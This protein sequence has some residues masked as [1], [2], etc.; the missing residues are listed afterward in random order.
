MMRRLSRRV[1]MFC[2]LAFGLNVMAADMAVAWYEPERGSAERADILN[3]IRPAIEAQLGG[4]VEFVIED[5]RVSDGWAFVIADPQRPGGQKID[6][7][8][9]SFAQ[10]AEFMDGLR[11]YALSREKNGR[12]Y[13]IDNVIGPTDVAFEPWPQFY[14]APREIFGF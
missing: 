10:D 14:G 4:D 8:D 1:V 9:T 7:Y 11:V 13:H 6:I 5:L 12:W 3:S 2:T